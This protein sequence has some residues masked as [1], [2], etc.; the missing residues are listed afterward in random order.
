MRASMP[1]A[2]EHP[3]RTMPC[4][5]N[6]L[7]GTKSRVVLARTAALSSSS[8]T[9]RP[10]IH[11]CVRAHSSPPSAN[12]TAWPAPSRTQATCMFLPLCQRCVHPPPSASPNSGTC[13]RSSNSDTLASFFFLLLLR[14]Q[15][16]LGGGRPLLLSQE[17]EHRGEAQQS[18]GTQHRPDLAVAKDASD[19]DARRDVRHAR[20][21]V[22]LIKQRPPSA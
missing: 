9:V 15:K 8:A 7:P 10:A 11:S 19:R 6:P 17:R 16:L 4:P 2:C 21:E 5:R 20:V 22:G 12:R 3:H 13:S 14:T 18:A 1:V